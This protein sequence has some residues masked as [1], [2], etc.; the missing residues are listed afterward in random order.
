MERAPL[1]LQLRRESIKELKINMYVAFF[2]LKK[3]SSHSQQATD[4]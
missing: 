1:K 2:V 3:E 4:R